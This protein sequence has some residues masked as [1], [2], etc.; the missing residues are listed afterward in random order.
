MKQKVGPGIVVAAVVVLVLFLGW[1]GWR[2]F[3][4]PSAREGSNP[5]SHMPASMGGSKAAGM[6]SYKNGPP[7][8]SG[9]APAGSPY[10]NAPANSQASSGSGP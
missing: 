2:M 10:A 3:A 4:P 8:S 1:Y 5:Y 7:S 6:A 9:G